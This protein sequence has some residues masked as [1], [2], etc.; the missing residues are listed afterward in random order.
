MVYT[1]QELWFIHKEFSGL[2]T[3]NLRVIAHQSKVERTLS[4][5]HNQPSLGPSRENKA[6]CTP[7]KQACLCPERA[8]SKRFCILHKE[9]IDSCLEK[10]KD[11]LLAMQATV[12]KAFILYTTKLLVLREGISTFLPFIHKK[13]HFF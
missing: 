11:C 6:A 3:K 13:K 8:R 2:Y 7:S 5:R 9:S 10:G 12:T 1:Q 4:S